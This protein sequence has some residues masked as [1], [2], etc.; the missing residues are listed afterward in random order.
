MKSQNQQPQ[1]KVRL[2]EDACF[3][4][5]LAIIKY[6]QGILYKTLFLLYHLQI[7]V[8]LRGH[9]PRA[10][11]HDCCPPDKRWMLDDVF[12]YE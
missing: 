9:V 1:S 4:I 6:Y 10:V 5:M 12:K 7:G 11:A 8:L 3:C 2:F